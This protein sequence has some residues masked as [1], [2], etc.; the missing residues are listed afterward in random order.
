MCV[1]LDCEGLGCGWSLPPSSLG[2]LVC[3]IFGKNS[4]RVKLRLLFVCFLLKRRPWGSRGVWNSFGVLGAS[5]RGQQWGWVL[6]APSRG[7]GTIPAHSGLQPVQRGALCTGGHGGE[8]FGSSQQDPNLTD[9]TP[10]A[11]A[12]Q[13]S[14]VTSHFFHFL[15]FY[16]FSFTY[17]L[18]VTVNVDSVE[19]AS[20]AGS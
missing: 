11:Q 7:A 5:K 13:N 3:V 14:H 1:A 6:A 9:L 16:F 17:D 20:G 4:C 10:K 12:T 2:F 18:T 19:F 8:Q 15:P